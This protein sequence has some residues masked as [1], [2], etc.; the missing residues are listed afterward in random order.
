MLNNFV[1]AEK[2][3]S[4]AN[5]AK[6][7][8]AL[9]CVFGTALL[10]G[11]SSGSAPN[12]YLTSP[13]TWAGFHANFQNTG[14]GTG[15]GATGHIK[16]QLQTGAPVFSVAAIGNDGTLYIGSADS[17]VYAIDPTNGAVKWKF[18]ADSSLDGTGGALGPDGTFYVGDTT[19]LYA[20]DTKTG[21]QKWKFKTGG[22]VLSSPVIANNNVYFGSFYVQ[23]IG[24]GDPSGPY[25]GHVFALDAATGTLKWSYLTDGAVGASPALGPDGT[26]YIGSYDGKVYA[27]DGITGKVRWT[28]QTG[29]PI[30]SSAAIGSN[31]LLYVGSH[32]S[33]L[34]ALD[35]Q[36]G[37]L[38][39]KVTTGQ[40]I[41]SS[42]GIGADG[43][44]YFGSWDGNLYSVNG[45]TGAVN[46][47]F[48][49][50][51]TAA[52]GL[53]D[54]SPCI[55][56][57]GTIYYETNMGGVLYALNGATGA[58]NWKINI[59]A[60]NYASIALDPNGTLYVGSLSGKLFAVN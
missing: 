51:T 47:K 22:F 8:A 48:F 41:V 5:S 44:V 57:D 59:D 17:F 40:R 25:D 56:G 35:T 45:S 24:E 39:F 32:D 58:V 12:A 27:F 10:G 19:S 16:W 50:S 36:T 34:Y 21:T 60:L 14:R 15:T 49:T 26:I 46:W 2:R 42:P 9:V 52:P 55:G 7:F 31:G 1:S 20:I 23:A 30:Q 43:T 53:N 38:A 4:M 29:A 28:Y 54:M 33:N 11:C 6:S 37:K 18:Q 13:A 3:Q